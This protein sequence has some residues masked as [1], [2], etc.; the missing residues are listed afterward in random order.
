M[1]AGEAAA[2]AGAGADAIRFA[3]G[4]DSLQAEVYG[5]GPLI[6]YS[7]KVGDRSVSMK[8]KY[9]HEFSARKRFES[10][11]VTASVNFKF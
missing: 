1:L 8:L 7:T 2:V 9:V 4:Q 5:I 11:V 3:T 10:D 6:T